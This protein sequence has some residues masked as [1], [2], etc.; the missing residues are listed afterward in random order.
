[1]KNTCCLSKRIGKIALIVLC[2]ILALVL[3]VLL[4]APLV[5]TIIFHDFF[6]DAEKEFRIP[7]LADGFVPQG[8]T[9]LPDQQVYLQCGYMSDGESASRI[10]TIPKSDPQKAY[11]VELVTADG[12]PYTGHTGGITVSGNFLWMANDGEGEDNCVWVLTIYDLFRKEAGETIPLK[13]SFRPETRAAYCFVEKNHLWVGEFYRPVDYPT[14]E[15]HTFSVAGGVE[16]HAL[17]ACYPLDTENELGIVPGAPT[18]LISVP[19]H[20]QGFTRDEYGHF[21][22]STSYG[23][24]KSHF[25]FYDNVMSTEIDG[26]LNVDGTDV[27]VWFLDEQVFKRD[28]EC[29][30]MSEEIVIYRD[31]IYYLTES[32]SKKYIFGNF[33]RGR[34]VYSIPLEH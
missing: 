19:N 14:K 32:A 4:V 11:Y 17:I 16:Q 10:Y 3:V 21:I 26:Y 33:I 24:S 2:A 20:V 5:T 34:H 9:Y 13:L 28:L 15:S 7:G 18:A 31:R 30:P 27:P 22:L 25:L 6:K 29:P 8:F 23:L 12:A 1:M